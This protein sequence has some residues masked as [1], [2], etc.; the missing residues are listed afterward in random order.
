MFSSVSSRAAIA[1]ILCAGAAHAEGAPAQ[2]DDGKAIVVTAS[3]SGDAIPAYLLGASVTLLDAAALEQRQTRIVSDVLRDVPGVAVSRAGG[4]GGLTALR[5]RGAEANHVLVLVDGIKASDPFN[6]EFDFGTLIADEAARIEV[7]RGQ[8]SALYGSDA[9]A[10]VV[11][12]ITLSGREAPGVSLR[13]EG[14]SFETLSAGARVG[15]V[16]GT[17]DYALTGT[18]FHTGGTPTARGGNRDVGSDNAGASAKLVWAPSPDFKVTGV[19]RYSYTDAELN[20][21]DGDAASPSFGY[22]IDSPG[23]H[24]RNEAF[25]GLVRAEATAFDGHWT[26]ALSFQIADTTRKGYDVPFSFLPR[27]GQTVGYAYGDKGRRYRGS[28]ESTVRFGNADVQN[29]FTFAV[30]AEREEFQNTS[31]PAIAGNFTGKRHSDTLGFVAQYDV[32]LFDRL[33][34]GGSLRIDDNDL[35][36]DS[37]TYRGQGSYRFGEGT[38]IHAAAGSGIKAPGFFE[39]FGFSDGRYTGNPALRPE[40]S[41]GWEAGVEQSFADR[42]VTLG[43]TY[44]SNRFSDEIYTT[45][46]QVGGQYVA[47]PD[48]RATAT[49]QKGVEAYAQARLG[50]GWRVDASYTWLDAKQDQDVLPVVAFVPTRFSGQAVRRAKHIASA[51]LSWA[52]VDGPLSAT[53][54]VRYNGAQND[55]AF[56]DPAYVPELVRLRS[57]TLVNFNAEYRLTPAIALFGRAENLLDRRYEE[58]FSFA[59]PGRAVYGGVKVRL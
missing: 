8:Q 41:E 33:A 26:S 20:A 9:I 1:A 6:G 34:L 52:P 50:D 35:F 12:Y 29:R 4:V 30:D 5:I 48:N 2:P 31:P 7:L 57:F 36:S 38:R 19:A 15:G 37:T 47:T 27:A 25:Y 46:V 40:R 39:L 54:T 56:V 14:G 42:A 45:Y 21:S 17:L 55:L 24:Y 11:N 18:Y 10:G 28:Y 23:A 51:N 49:R 44:F 58:V 22:T 13:A 59:T 16:A 3:R 32:T 43:A 53:L